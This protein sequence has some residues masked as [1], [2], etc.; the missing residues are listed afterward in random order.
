MLLLPRGAWAGT[1]ESNATATA[2][3]PAD[4]AAPAPSSHFDFGGSFRTLPV[5]LQ[6]LNLPDPHAR[7]QLEGAAVTQL[8]LTL[9]WK[10]ADWFTSEAHVV[11]V[12]AAS[13]LPGSVDDLTNAPPQRYRALGLTNTWAGGERS[14]AVVNV[15]RLTI[16]LSAPWFDVTVGRQAINF[17]KAYFFSPL[18]VFLP[19]GPRAIDREYKPGVDAVR[20]DVP[21]GDQSGANVVLAAGPAVDVDPVTQAFTPPRALYS[22]EPQTSALLARFFTTIGSWDLSAQGGSVYGGYHAAAGVAGELLTLGVRAEASYLV[23][24][25]MTLARAPPSAAS[26]TILVSGH[27]PSFVFSVDRRFENGLYISAEYFYNGAVTGD[28]FLAAAL[29]TRIGETTNLGEHLVGA[30]V[31]YEATPTMKIKAASVLS[32]HPE[33]FSASALVSP[34]VDWSVAENVDLTVGAL[35]MFGARPAVDPSGTTVARSEFGLF[36]NVYYAQFK[37]YFGAH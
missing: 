18:D 9:K 37:F 17:S 11:Q 20:V 8:R 21:I 34:S 28:S 26:P 36:P 24:R 5:A 13:T 25:H 7:K 2:A 14:A 19:F 33:H 35:L 6:P 15:D 22:A 3:P 23:S 27:H 10:P 4:G 1:P 16:K 12:F 29:R 30:L 32:I 31:T